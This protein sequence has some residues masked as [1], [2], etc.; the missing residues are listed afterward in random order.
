MPPATLW[1]RSVIQ[2]V[3]LSVSAN[4]DGLRPGGLEA[5]LMRRDSDNQRREA[6]RDLMRSVVE[7]HPE[8]PAI[9]IADT[10]IEVESLHIMPEYPAW[11][12]V[13]KS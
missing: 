7:Q 6:R 8:I 13:L 11:K 1:R 2:S 4:A 3:P 9:V 10:I 12:L 5:A